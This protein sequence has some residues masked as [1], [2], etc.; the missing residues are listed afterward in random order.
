[1]KD[2]IQI[3][4]ELAITWHGDQKYGEHPYSYHLNQVEQ[5]LVEAGLDSEDYR[6]QAWLHDILEDTQ[7]TATEIE[8]TFGSDMLT[9]IQAVSGFGENRRARNANIKSKLNDIE[10]PKKLRIRA[11]NTKAADR[12]ANVANSVAS[13]N[14]GLCRMYSKEFLDFK[15][16]LLLADF[17]LLEKLNQTHAQA[18]AFIKENES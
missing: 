11:Q 3:A 2:S 7:I 5:I 13:H 6:I 12:I 10:T 1:M 15:E 18:I 8:N 17:N 14:L 4:R 9:V 16:N